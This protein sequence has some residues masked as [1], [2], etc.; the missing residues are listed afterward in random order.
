MNAARLKRGLAA[1][2][3]LCVTAAV[4]AALAA[5]EITYRT[6]PGDT[7]IDLG[8]AMLVR[9][10]DWVRIQAL[11][12]IAD[13]LK[14][15][16]G[17]ELR[18]P[19]GLLKPLPRSGVVAA[20]AGDAKIDGRD[21][22]T[23]M[24]VG[25]GS[26]LATGDDGHITLQLPDGSELALP[27][28][29]SATIE[30]LNGF[31]AN[32][33]QDLRLRLESGRVESR[34]APQRGPSARYRIDTPTAV[35]GV[36]GTDFRVAWDA[37]EQ[38]SRAEVTQGSVEVTA[39]SGMTRL[40]KAGTGMA[41]AP[42]ARSAGPV[43][44]PGAPRLGA[45]PVLFDRPMLRVQLPDR[46][47]VDAWRVRVAP[48]GRVPA[49]TLFD[50]R[51]EGDEVRIAGL[52]DGEYR[53]MVRGIDARGL[54]GFDAEHLFRLAARPE[55]PFSL[56]PPVDGVVSAGEVA[57]GW[58]DAPEGAAYLFELAPDGR[59]GGD[60]VIRRELEATRTTIDLAPGRYT[61]RVATVNPGGDRGPWSDP[62][63]LEVR[64][65][66]APPTDPVVEGNRI[67]FSWSGQP[68]QRFDYQFGPDAGFESPRA[69]GTTD[70]P[71]V[72]LARPVS[73]IHYIRVRAIDPDGFV[74]EW[75]G[76]HKVDLGPGFPWPLLLIPV[77]AL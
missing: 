76:A 31:R 38:T 35:I 15:P 32:R 59:S 20:V 50:E 9:P 47:G 10:S 72:T 43:A 75:S 63:P 3:A 67:S 56:F 71:E 55:P 41:I 52:A 57:L 26:A 58:T 12:G 34:V 74:S 13:P 40:V 44:L 27:A 36:R 21:A 7:L 66:Q 6:E 70:V 64:P 19:V 46:A 30:R 77:L 2:A 17:L 33:L 54:E 48:V 51:I 69:A 14:L 25:A 62:V 1:L 60:G 49:P 39:K 45:L 4:P 24:R 53:L 61:W 65:A 18:I 68:G 8:T 29:S 42:G 11:N 23:G 22:S 28:R 5:D 16:V 73:G 37:G